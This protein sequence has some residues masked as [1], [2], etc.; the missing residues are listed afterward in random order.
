LFASTRPRLDATVAY[1]TD[2]E[3]V[4]ITMFFMLF[5]YEMKYSRLIAAVVI[6]RGILDFHFAVNSS[7]C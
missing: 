7:Y 3:F 6:S 2:R 4:N 1:M 5:V